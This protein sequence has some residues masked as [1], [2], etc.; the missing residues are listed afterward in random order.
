M[1]LSMKISKKLKRRGTNVSLLWEKSSSQSQVCCFLWLL[2][3]KRLRLSIHLL[4]HIALIN[5]T[6]ISK[7]I[8]NC[9]R[10]VIVKLMNRLPFCSVEY[11]ANSELLHLVQELMQLLLVNPLWFLPSKLLL[12]S[13]KLELR[14]RLCKTLHAV[15]RTNSS[16]IQPWLMSQ[17]QGYCLGYHQI[18]KYVK[19]SPSNPI[20]FKQQS[21]VMKLT[22]YHHPRLRM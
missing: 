7:R 6:I 16:S 17:K 18:S 13:A 5:R 19:L 11:H 9:N 4:V 15:Y 20:L 12:R 22:C 14:L 3:L 2:V 10:L 21:S 8:L 1:A